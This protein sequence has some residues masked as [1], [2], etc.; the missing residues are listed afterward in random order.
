MNSI[1][2]L[3]ETFPLPAGWGR[4][5]VFDPTLQL[6][7]LTI[8]GVGLLCQCTD[9]RSITASAADISTR[10]V[11][12]AYFELLERTSIVL[13]ASQNTDLV[14]IESSPERWRY[15]KSNGIAVGTSWPDACYRAERELIERDR[16][17]R[18]WF[19][20]PAPKELPQPLRG[21]SRLRELSVSHYDITFVSFDDPSDS[22]PMQVVGAFGF[23]KQAGAPTVYAFG[24][25]PELPDAIRHAEGEFVQ[26][27]IFLWGEPIDQNP[28]FSPTPDFHQEYF[29]GQRGETL[30]RAWLD[31]K[32]ESRDLYQALENQWPR[33]GSAVQYADLTPAHLREKLHVVRATSGERVPLIFGDGYSEVVGGMPESLTVH[34]VA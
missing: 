8:H 28:R 14:P 32:N 23:P 5:Q 3:T 33:Q 7:A 21:T 19:G 9:G 16:V 24:A 10:P 4:P 20:G 22:A 25:A 2:T 26:R 30:L 6:G 15:A 27:L 29:L 18:S 13:S 1:D 17:L 34:P 12:R 11:E 31:G